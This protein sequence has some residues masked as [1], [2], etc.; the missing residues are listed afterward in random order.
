MESKL[1]NQARQQLLEQSKKM[2]GEERLAA[3]VE[4]VKVI[5]QIHAAG[6]MARKKD[7]NLKP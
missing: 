6:V 7:G 5:A 4:H 2:T 1:A 3:Y